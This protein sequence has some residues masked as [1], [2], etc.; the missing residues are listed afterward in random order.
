M[1]VSPSEENSHRSDQ[2]FE[3]R[4]VADQMEEEDPESNE[5]GGERGSSAAGTGPSRTDRP[6]LDG[7]AGPADADRSADAGPPGPRPRTGADRRS[8]HPGP[9]GRPRSGPGGPPGPDALDPL[10][11]AL[12]RVRQG[13]SVRGAAATERVPRSSLRRA[14]VEAGILGAP[15]IV[16]RARVQSA[17]HD[18]SRSPPLENGCSPGSL[19]GA[20]EAAGQPEHEIAPAGDSRAAELE[21]HVASLQLESE[22]LRRH[23][24]RALEERDEGARQRDEATQQRDEAEAALARLTDRHERLVRRSQPGAPISATESRGARFGD[25]RS[26]PLELIVVRTQFGLEEGKNAAKRRARTTAREHE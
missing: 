8:M 9:A 6:R 26:I 13:E 21:R 12:S 25:L 16:P 15:A 17:L 5:E 7:P 22:E 19:P 20:R 14:A 4:G 11:R 10:S 24:E 23:L 3:S 2:E 1:T 18:V